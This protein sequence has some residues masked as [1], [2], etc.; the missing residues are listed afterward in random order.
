M[1]V[2]IYCDWKYFAAIVTRMGH[3]VV[4]I[5]INNQKRGYVLCDNNNVLASSHKVVC[6]FEQLCGADVIR[7]NQQISSFNVVE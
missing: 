3:L 4:N 5:N 6:M 1:L 2:N 7:L